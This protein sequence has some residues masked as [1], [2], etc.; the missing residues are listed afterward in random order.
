MTK[1]KILGGVLLACFAM[2]IL[3]GSSDRAESNNQGDK[4]T[5][6]RHVVI[7]KFKESSSAADVQKVVDGF[8]GLKGKIPEIASFEFGT[9]NSPEKLNDGFTHCFLVTFKSE[10]DRDVYLP[11]PAHKAF[12]DVLMPHLDK[13]MVIDYWAAE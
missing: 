9:N 10:K 6:L 3:I 12:V 1:T 13:A 8:R 11:H 4:K 7:F 2:L 5:M